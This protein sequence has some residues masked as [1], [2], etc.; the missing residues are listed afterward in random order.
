MSSNWEIFHTEID[1][2]LALIQF[3]DGLAGQINEFNLPNLVKFQVE[4]IG[5]A[6]EG[7][8]PQGEV[9]LLNLLEEEIE[10]WAEDTGSC[11][12][13][14]VTG[15]GCRTFFCYTASEEEDAIALAEHLNMHTGYEIGLKFEADPDKS[16]YWQGLYPTEEERRSIEDMKVIAHLQQMGDRL[17]NPREIEHFASFDTRQQADMF[18]VWA[19]NEKFVI[20]QVASPGDDL[21]SYLV[22]F[23]HTG[24]PL[25]DELTPHTTAIS[26]HAARL[27]GEYQ[28]WTCKISET[29][30]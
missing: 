1:G 14:R 16:A 8:A 29:L 4:F 15:E 18:V 17:E 7:M 12:A 28:G 11:Y 23:S 5:N 21:P 3:D 25:L 30:H 26:H 2:Q 6:P 22:V 10:S 9:K 20:E 13:G 19:R 27:G 24:C